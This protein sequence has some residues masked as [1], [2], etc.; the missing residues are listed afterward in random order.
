MCL[1]ETESKHAMAVTDVQYIVDDKGRRVA[2]VLDIETYEQLLANLEEVEAIRAFDSAKQSRD[3]VIPFE[4]A[5]NEIE[6]GIQR[7]P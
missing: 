7:R 6:Q 2:V 4:Q 5:V 3:E 1:P